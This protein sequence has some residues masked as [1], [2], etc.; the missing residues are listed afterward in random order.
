MPSK[1]DSVEADRAGLGA[2]HH[3]VRR[4]ILSYA[5]KAGDHDQPSDV[6][7]LMHAGEPAD[8]G[9]FA[10]VDPSAELTSAHDDG[11]VADDAVVTD[12][13]GRHHVRAV[14]DAGLMALAG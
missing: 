2:R 8:V 13:D 1:P 9:S 11:A 14:A 4:D 10:H 12:L 7:E 6:D 3:H 5:R